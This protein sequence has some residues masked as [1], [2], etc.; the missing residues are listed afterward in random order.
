[1]DFAFIQLMLVNFLPFA[2]GDLKEKIRWK[3]GC[4][5]SIAGGLLFSDL[6][7]RQ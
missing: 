3:M 7:W 2:L 5:R 1:V 6:C 4:K